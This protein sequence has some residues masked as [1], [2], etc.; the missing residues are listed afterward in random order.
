M[1]VLSAQ[2]L[3][4]TLTDKV[5][6]NDL[7][8]KGKTALLF[9]KIAHKINGTQVDVYITLNTRDST[10][11]RLEIESGCAFKPQDLTYNINP[12]D[13]L[14][15]VMYMDNWVNV[16]DEEIDLESPIIAR[17]KQTIL[18]KLEEII[19]TYNYIN[20]N[21]TVVGSE[22]MHKSAYERQRQQQADTLQT[23]CICTDD[24]LACE[25]L[26]CGHHIHSACLTD[27]Y[28]LTDFEAADREPDD[29]VD[30]GRRSFKC[31]VCRRHTAFPCW[32]NH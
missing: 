3:Y 7:K 24:T 22:L 17:Y 30:D 1:S 21:Y 23:C 12:F 16:S 28:N 6:N 26:S 15:P 9:K 5:K 29:D 2:S 18:G 19:E 32:K 4:N 20:A 8:C 25:Q 27:Y 13:T 10:R 11:L 31:A 14:E